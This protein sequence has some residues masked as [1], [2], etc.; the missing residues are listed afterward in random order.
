MGIYWRWYYGGADLAQ[1]KVGRVQ[2]F[3]IPDDDVLGGSFTPDDPLIL[4]GQLELTLPAGTP[5][6]LPEYAW[7]GERYEGYPVVPDDPIVPDQVLFDGVSPNVTIDGE[8]IISDANERAFY[9]PA[10]PLDPIV[11]YATPTDY[12]SVAAVYYQGV[13]FVSPPLTPGVH[14]IHLYEPYIIP[15]GAYEGAP[16]GFG[17]IYD[18]TWV[19]TVQ[20]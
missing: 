16:D 7:V 8:T 12:G 15:A 6:V 20:P 2:L 11:N 10:M 17:V 19:I 14:V 5:F 13:A 9:I 3:P 1:S 4:Q 18:N